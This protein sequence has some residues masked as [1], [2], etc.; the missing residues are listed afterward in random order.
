[1]ISVTPNE[2]LWELKYRPKSIDESILPVELKDY[3]KQLV[4]AGEL[5]NMILCSSNPGTGKTTM[6]RAMVEEMDMDLLFINASSEAGIDVFRTDITKF[7]STVSMMGSGKVVILDEAD[8]LSEPAQKAFRGIIEEFSCNCR[9]ILTCNYLNRIIEPIRS[10]MSV[11]EF[12]IPAEDKNQMIKHQVIRLLEILKAENVQVENKQVIMELVKK[13]FPDNRSM[14]VDLQSYAM[15]GVIDEGIL[16]QVT[17]GSDVEVLVGHLK[18]KQFK[19]I[20]AL[21]PKYASDYST[22]IRALYNAMFSAVKPS[23]IPAM[24]EYIG[25]NQKYY[26]SVPDIEIH[27]EYLCVQLMMNMD[28]K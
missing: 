12:T 20:R 24:I 22:F 4:A 5:Q 28:F 10:R 13:H 16:G 8:N 7:A 17:S 2:W 11:K 6:A 15:K 14:L 25:E 18:A 19:E 1:M 26:N 3:F 27:M 9:F 23:H 21:I